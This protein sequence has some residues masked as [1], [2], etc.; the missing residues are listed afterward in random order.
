MFL[1]PSLY[2]NFKIL[3]LNNAIIL[4]DLF[5]WEGDTISIN[6]IVEYPGTGKSPNYHQK[7]IISL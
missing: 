4:W 5:F 2:Y 6:I 1:F 3:S 7:T